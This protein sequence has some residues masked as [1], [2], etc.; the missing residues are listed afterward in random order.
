MTALLIAGTSARTAMN[1]VA[2]AAGVS[3]TAPA[4]VPAAPAASRQYA[5]SQAYSAAAPAPA[6][7]AADGLAEE[8]SGAAAGS[9]ATA[10]EVGGADTGTQRQLL[11]RKNRTKSASQAPL[12]RVRL[13]SKNAT[14]R[15]G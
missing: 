3:L 7:T 6:S 14:G 4:A 10:G 11:V 13:A 2:K 15:A 1:L 9:D 12:M 8:V 5:V